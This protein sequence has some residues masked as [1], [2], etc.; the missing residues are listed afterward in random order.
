M[1]QTR[2]A[3]RTAIVLILSSVTAM[4]FADALVKLASD[5]LTVWQVFVARSAVALPLLA[6]LMRATCTP[7]RPTAPGWTLVRCAFLVLCWLCFYASLP[8][9]SLAV[10]AVAMYSAPIMIALMSA[11]VLGEP[12][13]RRQWFA[14]VLGFL[15]VVAV[16]RPGSDAFTWTTLLPVFGAVLYAGAMVLTRG[17]TRHEPPLVLGFALQGAFLVTGAVGSFMVGPDL[18]YAFLQGGWPPLAPR[19]WALTALL[20]LLSAG[21]FVGVARAYQT[22]TP[23]VIATFDY[24]YLIS[25]ALWGVVF[26]ADTPD[27]WTVVGMVLITAAGLSVAAPSRR[28]AGRSGTEAAE[29]TAAA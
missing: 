3:D 16:L 26:F 28:R 4:A 1:T 9:L 25:A 5:D 19:D 10:A 11:A 24:A 21:Y 23:S 22:G 29:E 15:G 2:H 18:G 13:T 14:V 6:V 8:V 17:K 20:G 12:V 7:L 27:A